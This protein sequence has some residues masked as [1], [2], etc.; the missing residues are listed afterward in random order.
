MWRP[1]DLR[2][3]CIWMVCEDLCIL[4]PLKL[5]EKLSAQH[6][7]EVL[8]DSSNHLVHGVFPEKGSSMTECLFR[9]YINNI[10]VRNELLH[11]LTFELIILDKTM[12]YKHTCYHS[13]LLI[14]CNLHSPPGQHP[15]SFLQASEKAKQIQNVK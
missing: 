4:R 6:H 1:I 12:E 3:G 2:H 13:F 14:S 11:L 8:S 10:T 7:I 9:N 5:I 15:H